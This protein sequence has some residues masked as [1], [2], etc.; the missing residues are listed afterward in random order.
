MR[1][2]GLMYFLLTLVL[3]LLGIVGYSAYLTLTQSER[4]NS[5]NQ[6]KQEE[7][8]D[9]ENEQEEGG[10]TEQ[11][12]EEEEEV[13]EA[14]L[15][16]G[17]SEQESSSYGYKIGVPKNWYYRFFSSTK[18]IGLDPDPIPEASEYAGVITFSIDDREFEEMIT[19]TEEYLDNETKSEIT[20]NGNIW[21]EIEGEISM[22][23]FFNPGESIL[24]AM[25][26]IEGTSYRLTLLSPD[27]SEYR[28]IY[29]QLLSTISFE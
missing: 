6:E 13:K 27:N 28:A 21:T 12:P 2:K 4:E 24:Y 7:T 25:T 10:E 1:N 18:M 3:I 14:E 5:D 29:T 16:E 11:E 9:E 22:D 17:W 20:V 26:S 15:P 19:E 8:D 23:D